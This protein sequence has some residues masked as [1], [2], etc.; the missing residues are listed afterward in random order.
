MFNFAR[1]P[2]QAQSRLDQDG[3]A[4]VYALESTKLIAPPAALLPQLHPNQAK[5][6]PATLAIVLQVVAL[7]CVLAI[8]WLVQWVAI[9]YFQIEFSLPLF[10]RALLLA[11]IA[12]LFSFWAGMASW[13]RWIHAGFPLA[14][15]AMTRL[16]L[17]S[18]FYLLGFIVSLTL[19]WT[20]FRS[21]VPFFPSRPAVWQQVA[22]LLQKRPV[23]II[24]IGSGLGDLSMHLSSLRDDCQVEGIE[25]APLPWLLSYLRARMPMRRSAAIFK[26]GSYHAIDFGDYD[27]V[28][29][30]LSPAA[31]PDLWQKAKLEMRPG[32]ILVSY[33]FNIPGISPTQVVATGEQRPLL[34]VWHM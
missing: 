3:H 5:F 11:V 9:I 12:A 29:A 33:E 6:L 7:L 20:T 2:A 21:Q 18:E 24:D 10:V 8:A 28:F 26:L 14:I 34:Y 17:P 27:F 16:Q 31:M 13:W 23:R 22:K 1:K 25:I 15:W 4:E 19:F 32:S 30:Y